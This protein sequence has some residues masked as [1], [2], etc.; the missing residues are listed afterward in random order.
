[1]RQRNTFWRG[2]SAGIWIIQT[3]ARWAQ[4]QAEARGLSL[5]DY[6]DGRCTFV[7]MGVTVENAEASLQPLIPFGHLAYE[8]W[9][10][11]N[12][13]FKSWKD[14]YDRRLSDRLRYFFLKH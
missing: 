8:A 9:S 13:K 7:D 1:M 4:E 10:G 5:H 2:H 12:E 11:R 6:V 14:W 3:A